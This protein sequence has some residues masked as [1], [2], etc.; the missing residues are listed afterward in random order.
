[1]LTLKK[2]IFKVASR[3]IIWE[4]K[5]ESH[6]LNVFYSQKMNALH[7]TPRKEERVGIGG[8]D[9]KQDTNLWWDNLRICP[10]TKHKLLPKKI[11]KG[12]MTIWRKDFGRQGLSINRREFGTLTKEDSVCWPCSKKLS[13]PGALWKFTNKHQQKK[14]NINSVADHQFC[15]RFRSFP[16][17]IQGSTTIR[18]N[19]KINIS[20][21]KRQY[22]TFEAY[23]GSA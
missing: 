14:W 7:L 4:P 19:S 22:P 20:I 21:D 18:W 2:I 11:S 10:W 13:V 6:F 5:L 8:L 17:D 23:S 1:M 16:W 3:N 9:T 15:W 12:S